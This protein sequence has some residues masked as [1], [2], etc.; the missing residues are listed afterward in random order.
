MIART[1]LHRQVH[2]TAAVASLVALVGCSDIFD[3]QNPGQIMDDDLNRPD[4]MPTLVTGMSADLS[5]ALDNMI[6]VTARLSDEM[7]GSGNYVHTALFRRGIVERE[8]VSGVWNATQRARWVAESGIE[9]M[10]NVLGDEF[11][12][13]PLTARAY[14]FAG[15]SNRILGENFCEVVY[16]GG[17]AQNRSVAFERADGHFAEAIRHAQAAGAE[18]IR[19]AAYGGRAQAAVGLGDWGAAVTYAAEVPT[20]FV[21]YAIYSDNSAQEVNDVWTFTHET[22][23][24]GAYATLAGSFVPPDPRAPY[25]DCRLGGCPRVVGQDGTT[26]HFRQEKYPERGSDIPLVKGT[27]MRLIEAEALLLDGQVGPAMAKINEVRNFWGLPDLSAAN[28]DEA[29][30][31]LDDER[32]LTL[33]L[34]ARRLFDLHRWDHEFLRGGTIVYP[35]VENRASC[36]IFPLSECQTNPNL[37][38][39]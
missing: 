27:E 32:H 15:L 17:P 37:S 35:G 23:E 38:C 16:D 13:N 25:T 36:L 26:P 30:D 5:A 14:L 22:P 28:E 1:S 34:E 2:R 18:A 33:W 29:W 8:Y 10:R 21:Y 11:E 4:A 19:L 6:Y 3:V 31:H 7:A 12:G 20:D 24:M 39:S 9:R